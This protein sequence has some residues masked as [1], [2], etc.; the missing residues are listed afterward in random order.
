MLIIVRGDDMRSNEEL[1]ELHGMLIEQLN[2][3]AKNDRVLILPS[4]CTYNAI[5]DYDLK[6]VQVV[7]DGIE[8]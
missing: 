2:T 1:K 4:D 8:A 7:V 3:D 5:N 6:N